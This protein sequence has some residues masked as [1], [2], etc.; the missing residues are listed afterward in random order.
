[1]TTRYT[2]PDPKCEFC[3]GTGEVNEDVWD[4]D[5]HAYA[6]TGT[7]RCLCTM[8]GDEDSGEYL[9]DD[10]PEDDE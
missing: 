1:M 5:A 3:G 8:E 6:P 7:K 2:E 10:E 9:E 4:D